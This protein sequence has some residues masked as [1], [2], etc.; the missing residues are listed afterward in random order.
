VLDRLGEVLALDVQRRGLTPAGQSHQAPAGQVVADLTDRADRVVQAEVTEL[1]ALLDHLQHQV[2]AA[3]LEQGG[4]LGHVRVADDHMQAAVALGV[5][6]RLVA[7]V[8][9]RPGTGG[10]AGDA[11]PDVLGALRQAVDGAAWRLQDLAR[12]ADELACD[13]E[14]Q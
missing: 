3:D 8:D 11:F 14:R 9:D 6:V 1:H 12:A 5:G 4:R 10:R 2:G 7:R 13:E